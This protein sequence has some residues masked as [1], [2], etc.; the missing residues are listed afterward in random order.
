MPVSLQNTTLCLS[1]ISRLREIV[2]QTSIILNTEIDPFTIANLNKSDWWQ[3]ENARQMLSQALVAEGYDA[4][5]AFSI[6]DINNGTLTT[7]LVES[8]NE[9]LLNGGSSTLLEFTPTGA[10]ETVDGDYQQFTYDGESQVEINLG[11]S[12]VNVTAWFAELEEVVRQQ[13]YQIELKTPAVVADSSVEIYIA[14]K[15]FDT[16]E[17]TESVSVNNISLRM[18]EVDG[19][20]TLTLTDVVDS[21]NDESISLPVATAG[22]VVSISLS[23]TTLTVDYDG[24]VETITL[25]T[26]FFTDPN[27][28]VVSVGT[29]TPPTLS[30]SVNDLVE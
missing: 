2:L 1:E 27:V 23:A 4:L 13:Q 25:P 18:S 30:I 8:I 19:S 15:S 22:S 24:T 9:S 20:A 5:P 16:T 11:D 10:V 3:Y 12:T 28:I 29:A 6:S 26:G 14:D 21:L 7:V 17:I